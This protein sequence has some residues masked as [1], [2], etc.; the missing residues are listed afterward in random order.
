MPEP[1]QIKRRETDTA[2]FVVVPD[3]SLTGDPQLVAAP[4]E[5]ARWTAIYARQ[6]RLSASSF[7]S[8]QAQVVICQ[9]SAQSQSW[10]VKYEFSDEGESS[11]KLDRPALQQLLAAIKSGQV[12]RLV[13]Y[14][15]DRLS[16]RLVDLAKLFQLFETH[17][18]ELIVVTD[19][20]YGPSAT[21][22][23]ATNIIAA[24]SQF[25]Q[26]LNR[27]RM[28]E[29]R[30]ALKLR[31]K[32]VGGRVPFGYRVAPGTKALVPHPEQC[33]VVR[34]FFEL[35]AT[36]KRPSE[37]ARCANLNQWRD[38]RGETEKWTAR[39][40]AMLLRNPTYVG[41][42]R[43]GKQTLPGEHQAI[44][45]RE[46]FAAVDGHLE[47][48]RTRDPKVKRSKK[49]RNPYGAKLIG[50]LVCGK[51]NRPMSI[52]VSH[53]GM[54]RYVYYR[55]RSQAGG[56]PP[57]PG[58]N[59]QVYEIEQFLCNLLANRDVAEPSIPAELSVVWNRLKKH[60]REKS[61]RKVIR[62]VVYHPA[63]ERISL[64]LKDAEAW[65]SLVNTNLG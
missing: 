57:C 51:C 54:F 60:S 1:S 59:V 20:N 35:A 58:V 63:A 48:R 43:N 47:A 7:S 50:L 39:R 13:V 4:V 18:V 3:R 36:D 32:R 40:V 12:E 9:D 24:A 55:C 23:L 15:I 46:L 10:G 29:M 27:E 37:L 33:E 64:E 56:L 5:A 28:A 45:S 22:R 65:G 17:Q 52:S 61:L 8:C 38:H 26:D 11:E 14:S 34:A 19:P 53:R 2:R 42:L 16:R 41:E 21:S 49:H 6:S 44:V 25:Q 31:G 62:R 30:L